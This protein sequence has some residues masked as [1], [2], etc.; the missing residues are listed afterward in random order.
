[1]NRSYPGSAATALLVALLAM[2]SLLDGGIAAA[3]DQCDDPLAALP[4]A[5][6][7]RYVT[8]EQLLR[9]D[10]AESAADYIEL[11]LAQAPEALAVIELGARAYTAMGDD[12]R[13]EEL[14]AEA[15]RLCPGREVD[16]ATGG[17]TASGPQ[18][19]A[20]SLYRQTLEA[21]SRRERD[22]LLPRAIGAY[23]QLAEGETR[24]EARHALAVLYL[25]D[26]RLEASR[27][28]YAW[29]AEQKALAAAEI[30]EYLRVLRSL[31]HGDRRRARLDEAERLLADWRSD[32]D[33]ATR[34]QAERHLGFIA[35]HLEQYETA[36]RAFEQALEL[37]P[38]DGEASYGMAVICDYE[39]RRLRAAGDHRA[40]E[41][42]R[43]LAVGYARGAADHPRYGEA[44]RTLLGRLQ[45]DD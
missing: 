33:R 19:E 44:A 10:D 22:L 39:A 11:M 17:G 30:P 24:V 4:A 28:A 41:R 8:A 14:L 9:D 6:R 27:A 31:A 25:L 42:Q 37:A 3:G 20:R 7:S 26:E 5:L 32:L 40:A 18:A 15:E 38:Q 23:E 1:M 29:L 35:M 34:A 2:L 36:R 21:G 45:F 12:E 43:E 13:V 16:L